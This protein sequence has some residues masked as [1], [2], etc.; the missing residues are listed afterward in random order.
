MRN[1]WLEVYVY[2]RTDAEAEAAVLWSSDVHRRL[3]GN[4]PDAGKD[5]GQKEERASEDEMAGRHHAMSVNLGKLQ[6]MLRDRKAWCAAVH[7]VTKS[8]T[9]LRD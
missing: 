8:W 1:A 2:G 3:T 5:Q 6:E 9:W 4:V 7:G